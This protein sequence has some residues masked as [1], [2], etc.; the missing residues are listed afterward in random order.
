MAV[1]SDLPPEILTIIFHYL[2]PLDFVSTCLV[3]KQ[4]YKACL[5]PLYASFKGSGGP[6]QTWRRFQLFLN[7]IT[8]DDALGWH[9]KSV[10]INE[11]D[12]YNDDAA[13]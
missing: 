10:L 13:V 8:R 3:S 6:K 9:V 11:I 2:P 4:V 1:L 12:D 5:P 7:M